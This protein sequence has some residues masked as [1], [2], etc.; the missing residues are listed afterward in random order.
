MPAALRHAV[1]VARLM[2]LSNENA[3]AVLVLFR[4]LWTRRS[5]VF[6][7][8]S[9]LDARRARLL[10]TMA[11]QVARAKA[12]RA[13]QAE[14]SEIARI[15]EERERRAAAMGPV[16]VPLAAELGSKGERAWRRSGR[17][18]A[19]LLSRVSAGGPYGRD[20]NGPARPSA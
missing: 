14:R 11:S 9:L 20:K 1:E 18:R 7:E 3:T 17:L 19:Q 10:A 15:I 5:R 12:E 6:A 2:L 13:A 8:Q 16:G 4:R